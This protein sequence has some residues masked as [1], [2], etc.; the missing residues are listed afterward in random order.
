MSTR[1]SLFAACGLAGSLCLGYALCDAVQA[2]RN[3][4]HRSVIT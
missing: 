3:A 2:A 4:V 1:K